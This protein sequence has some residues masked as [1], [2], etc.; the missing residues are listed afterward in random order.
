LTTSQAFDAEP[1]SDLA[2]SPGREEPIFSAKHKVHDYLAEKASE[3]VIEFTTIA[4]GP[5][6]DWGMYY[7][8]TFKRKELTTEQDLPTTSSSDSI[9]LPRA[10]S[11]SVEGTNP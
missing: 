10:Q 2:H 4:T 7:E 5:F 8:T 9:F 11:S 3:G 1:T 6:F